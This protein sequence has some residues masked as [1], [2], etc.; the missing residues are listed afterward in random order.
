M[1]TNENKVAASEEACLFQLKEKGM[2]S[3]FFEMTLH[4]LWSIL[5][6]PS[7]YKNPMSHDWL[8]I[9][10]ILLVL[11]VLTIGVPDWGE[12][13]HYSPPQ[14]KKKKTTTTTTTN[15]QTN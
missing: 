3:N 8:H 9:L 7:V 6:A 1:N 13:E 10:H 12:G 11:N 5:L 2:V 15:K 4:F 14:K